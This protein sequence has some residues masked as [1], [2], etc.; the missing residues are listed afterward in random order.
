MIWKGPNGSKQPQ[1]SRTVRFH[2]FLVLFGLDFFG[3]FWAVRSGFFVGFGPERTVQN[4]A[5]HDPRSPGYDRISSL[6]I[7]SW[8]PCGVAFDRLLSA[9]CP[10]LRGK[11]RPRSH[12]QKYRLWMAV[13]RHMPAILWQTFSLTLGG[14]TFKW[15]G[16]LRPKSM[17]SFE[18]WVPPESARKISLAIP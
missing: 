9:G 4:P 6:S 11:N 15:F 5:N 18:E 13:K 2:S 10:S 16:N 12:I 3:P 17:N 1:I 14:P 7:H 8:H